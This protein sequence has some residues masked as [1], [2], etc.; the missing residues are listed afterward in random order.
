MPIPRSR[1]TLVTGLALAALAIFSISALRFAHLQAN[2]MDLGYQAQMFWQLSHGHWYDF[3]SV[4]QTPALAG[5]GALTMYPIAYGFRYLGGPYFLFALQAGGIVAAAWGLFRAAQQQ[6]WSDRA[7]TAVALLFCIYP[8]VLGGSQFDYHPDFIAL[9]FLMWAYVFYQADRRRAY[10]LCLLAAALSKNMALFGIAGWGLGLLLYRR[11]WRDGIAVMLG[12]L[13]LLGV[14]LDW[15]FPRYL[16]GATAHLNASLYA[17]LGHG[18][19]GIAVGIVTRFPA[20][21]AHLATEPAY[22]LW[23]LGP[24]FGIALLGSAA[25]PAFVALFALNAVS[26]LPEQHVVASQYQVLLAGWLF[27]AL[28][29]ALTRWPAWRRRWLLASAVVSA[30]GTLALVGIVIVPELLMASP[31]PASVTAALQVVPTT[32]VLFVQ[33]HVGSLAYRHPVFGQDRTVI[34]HGALLDG[35]PALWR[36]APRVPT[37]LVITA[38]T[39][40]YFGTVAADALRAGYHVTQHRPGVV[41]VTGTQHFAPP[42]IGGR[43]SG[44]QLARPGWTLPAWTRTTQIGHLVW[45]A[46]VLAAPRGRAGWLVRPFSTW[47]P[48]GR[49]RLVAT[50]PPGHQPSGSWVCYRWVHTA[51]PWPLQGLAVG[52]PFG[53]RLSTRIPGPAA[54]RPLTLTVERPNWFACGVWTTGR[55]TWTLQSVFLKKVVSHD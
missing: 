29:E 41:V 15:L 13:A 14:E 7:A 1:R 50:V 38:P 35:L 34:P 55:T 9:P 3:S 20:V 30:A 47:L 43:Q 2:T 28:I 23:I 37:A 21:L 53:W 45:P 17:Y 27:L 16:P 32:D 22:A 40:L 52:S 12:A 6:G 18:L 26:T 36:E 44:W 25:V 19:S 31:P 49:Y 5:D 8:A 54:L 24:V 42:V 48:P 51:T 4:F 11:R 10:Y 33:T 46:G 39:T